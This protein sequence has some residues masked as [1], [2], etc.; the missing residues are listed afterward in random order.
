MKKFLLKFLLF[1]TCFF[2]FSIGLSHLLSRVY[3]KSSIFKPYAIINLKQKPTHL[4]L[5]SS[6]ALTTLNTEYISRVYKDNDAIWY[7][8]AMDDSSPEIH[9]AMLEFIVEKGIIPQCVYLQ[10]DRVGQVAKKRNWETNDYRFWPGRGRSQ[11][12]KQYFKGK[13]NG[14]LYSFLPILPYAIHNSEL[15]FPAFFVNFKPD[16]KHRFN[17]FGDVAYPNSK[18]IKE[19]PE[20]IQ[21]DLNTSDPT[22]LSIKS[23]CDDNKIK[24]ILFIAPHLRYSYHSDDADVC[25]FSN[26]LINPEYF[27]D[28]QHI[29]G[30]GRQVFTELFVREVLKVSK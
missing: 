14:Y 13:S 9:L 30:K 26:T 20:T 24:L 12:L 22:L 3:W 28:H 6:R 8:Y 2:L 18:T 1:F 27:Y 11:S 21:K 7:N 5:G 4:I 16:Y 10:Y 23:F 25:N 17:D 29:N 19:T 15:I